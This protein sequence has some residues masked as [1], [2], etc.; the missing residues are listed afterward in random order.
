MAGEELVGGDGLGGQIEDALEHDDAILRIA[1]LQQQFP[2]AKAIF[3]GGIG[4]ADA[5]FQ[6]IQF[7][8]GFAKFFQPCEGGVSGGSFP[9]LSATL[10]ED[11][12]GIIGPGTQFESFFQSLSGCGIVTVFKFAAAE[13]DPEVGT[14]EARCQCL[15]QQLSGALPVAGGFEGF[16]EPGDSSGFERLN[17]QRAFKQRNGFA[18]AMGIAEQFGEADDGFQPF[19]IPLHR[20]T[21]IGFCL[22]VLLLK[23][24]HAAADVPRKG[25]FGDILHERIHQRSGFLITFRSEEPD[26]VGDADIAVVAGFIG[27]QSPEPGCCF[28]HFAALSL[29]EEQFAFL[30]AGRRALCGQSIEGF[31]DQ[32]RITVAT[33]G[34][35]AEQRGVE[36]SGTEDFSGIEPG[37]SGRGAVRRQ[38]TFGEQMKG[39]G[40]PGMPG[41]NGGDEQYDGEGTA[42]SPE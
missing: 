10:S 7:C 15:L 3:D 14:F 29:E 38:F 21:K 41:K 42:D 13:R 19:R 4:T 1:V 28:G 2:G 27:E 40:P 12:Q 36:A 26:D 23:C 18:L 32:P 6:L 34:L 11:K 17:R 30:K 39:G 22:W 24:K 25:I 33:G 31:A 35:A 9:E 16:A 37:E 20:L 5:V 8:G